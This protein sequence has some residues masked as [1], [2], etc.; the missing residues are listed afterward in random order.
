MNT[1]DLQA[2][3]TALTKAQLSRPAIAGTRR[4]GMKKRP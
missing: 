3:C 4:G 2:I 1:V